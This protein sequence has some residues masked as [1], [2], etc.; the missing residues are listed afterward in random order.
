MRMPKQAF[1]L[2]ELLVVIAIIAL[3]A[4]LIFPV[5]SR[6]REQG[7]STVCLSNIRQT[8]TSLHLYLQDYDETYPMNRFPDEKHPEGKCA[9]VGNAPYP[10]STSEDSRINWRR[11]IQPYLKSRQAMT[12]PSNPYLNNSIY[13][14]YPPGD[15]TNRLYS[16]KDYLPLSYAY[17]GNFFHEAVPSC[18]YKEAKDRPRRIAEISAPTNLIFLL[19]SRFPSPDLGSWITSIGLDPQGR[20]YYQSHNAQITFLFADLHVKRLK[21]A[22]TCTGKMWTDAFPDGSSACKDLSRLPDEYK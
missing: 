6:A 21:F 13:P 17:N 7:R 1:T 19:D 9:L 20:G 3:L 10:I 16:P 8:G 15:Q 4:A 22:A 5:F 2:I 14:G 11:V 12:C 18:L